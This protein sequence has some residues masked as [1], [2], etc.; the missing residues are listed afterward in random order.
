[1]PTQTKFVCLFAPVLLLWSLS[2][3]LSLECKGSWTRLL[4][5]Q[6]HL[7]LV[8]VASPATTCRRQCL[9]GASR[10]SFRPVEPKHVHYSRPRA[11]RTRLFAW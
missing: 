3:L 11:L 4:T 1:M 5:K 10:D 6:T 8:R 2:S 9:R 7:I